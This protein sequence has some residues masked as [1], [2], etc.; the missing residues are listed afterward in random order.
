MLG[1]LFNEKECYELEYLLRKELEEMML[2]LTDKRIDGVVRRA[3][4]ERYHIVFRM[5]ARMAKPKELVKY[6]RSKKYH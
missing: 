3:I 4:E 5:Y 6:V 2:D 1:F